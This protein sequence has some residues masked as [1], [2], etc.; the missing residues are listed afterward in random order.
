[1]HSGSDKFSL[2]PIINKLIKQHGVGLHV[3]TAGT[4]W[5]EEVI[6]LARAGGEGLKIAKKIYAGGVEHFEALTAPYSTVIDIDPTKL[7]SIDEVND[8]TWGQFVA[9]L[10]HE[11]SNPAYNPHLRQLIHVGFKIAAKMGD[12]YGDALKLH[13]DVIGAGVT[14]NLW[15]RH[16]KPIFG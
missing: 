5:L 9:A 6:G 7:P 11:P 4:T 16:I 2:Y 15:A 8:W 3:K 12:R 13:A 10:E 14:N 1:M